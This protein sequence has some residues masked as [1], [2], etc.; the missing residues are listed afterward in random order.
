MTLS[1]A[2]KKAEEWRGSPAVTVLDCGDRLAFTF[3]DDY[4]KSCH[5]FDENL[6][7]FVKNVITCPDVI[8][9]FMFKNDGRFE[10][11]C[12]GKY[13]DLLRTGISVL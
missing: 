7:D 6:P 9:T 4:P 2:I 5:V 12:V 10:S 8:H 13:S 3:E 1:A 11:F